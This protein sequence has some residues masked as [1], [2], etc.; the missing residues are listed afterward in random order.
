MGCCRMPAPTLASYFLAVRMVLRKQ[1]TSN[2]GA[3]FFLV[4]TLIVIAAVCYAAF[5]DDDKP[6]APNNDNHQTVKAKTYCSSPGAIGYTTAGTKLTCRK[7]SDGRYRWS[8]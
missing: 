7:S 6:H 2:A 3:V 5:S 1:D 8:R 4:F